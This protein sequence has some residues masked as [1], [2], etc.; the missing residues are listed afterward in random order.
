[1][2]ELLLSCSEWNYP[3]AQTMVDGREYS[4]HTKIPKDFDIILN[5]LIQLRWTLLSM[6]NFIHK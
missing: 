5:S 2:G 1:M 6:I 4:T 3:D